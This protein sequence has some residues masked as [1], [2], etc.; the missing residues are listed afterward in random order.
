MRRDTMLA[1]VVASLWGIVAL[2]GPASSWGWDPTR[3]PEQPV[4][5]RVINHFIYKPHY[6]HVYHAHPQPDPYAYRYAP[7]AYYPYSSS[8]YWVH[9]TQM[10]YRYRYDYHGPKY[11]YQPSWGAKRSHD[12]GHEP[13][14]ARPV[15]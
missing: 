15:K 3:A 5:E 6:R 1:A 4:H 12:H 2:A 13:H 8:A 11:R 14:A 10:R 9:A 7:C